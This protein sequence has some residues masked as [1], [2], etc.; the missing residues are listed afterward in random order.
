V[1]KMQTRTNYISEGKYC[2]DIWNTDGR[3]TIYKQREN[4]RGC[5]WPRGA[6]TANGTAFC[7]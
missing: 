3:I 7:H 5:N 2:N 4:I 6:R 1:N